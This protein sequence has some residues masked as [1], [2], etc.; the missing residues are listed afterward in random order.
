MKK[1]FLSIILTLALF[2]SGG[3]IT[4]HAQEVCGCGCNTPVIEGTT[5]CGCGWTPAV[6][7]GY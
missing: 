2:L 4:S 6:P 3:I 5:H 1:V 7:A